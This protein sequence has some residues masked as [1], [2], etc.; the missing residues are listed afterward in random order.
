MQ[1]AG[2]AALLIPIVTMVAVFTF[3]SIAVWAEERRKEREAHYRSELMNMT[4]DQPGDAAERILQLLR[5]EEARA[6]VQKREGRR[7]GGLVTRTVGVGVGLLFYALDPG[8][9]YWVIGV[10][11]LL[12]GAVI[13]GFSQFQ[14]SGTATVSR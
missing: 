13:F 10:I 1:N 4:L 12:I 6:T 2:S 3:L 11:P 9:L 14:R 5:E 7:L 8:K